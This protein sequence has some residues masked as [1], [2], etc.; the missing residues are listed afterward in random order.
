MLF[1]A[2]RAWD[3]RWMS[4][5]GFIHLRVVRQLVSGNGLVFNAGERVEAS[6]SPL[7]VLLLGTADLLTPVRLEWLAVLG[8]IVL[9]LVGVVLAALA[10]RRLVGATGRD[11]VVFPV[12]LAVVVAIPAMWTFTSSG[13][14]GGLVTA[15]LGVAI[16][17]MARWCTGDAGLSATTA[18]FLGLGPL[19]RPD[20]AIFAGVL[21]AVVLA[22]TWRTSTWTDRLRVV[23]LVAAVPVAYQVFRMG[24]YGVL[25]PNTAIAK[26]ASRSWWSNGWDYLRMTADPYWLWVPAVVLALGAYLPLV[27]TLR[28]DGRRR[29]LL[30]A[31]A[32]AVSGLVHLG[33]VLRVGGDFMPSRLLLPGI[34]A[35]CAPVAVLPVRRRFAAA[36]L[37]L[38][39]AVVCI[40]SLREYSDTHQLFRRQVEVEDFD[41]FGGRLIGRGWFD[42]VGLYYRSTELPADPSGGREAAVAEYGIGLPSYA[43]GPDVYII[44][45]LGLA[46]PVTAHFELERRGLIP[47]HEKPQPLPWMVARFADPPTALDQEDIPPIERNI[48]IVALDR[49]PRGSF[50]E[51][52]A[53]ARMA[54]SCRELEEL[55]ASYTGDLTPGRVLENLVESV[56]NTRL[57]Y[58][59]EPAD[60]QAELCDG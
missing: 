13:L 17:A 30:V 29:E 1:L 35:V 45:M 22:A 48:G 37:V 20:L 28:Q 49:R 36:A 6:T 51:R 58:P 33:Y 9:T 18:L 40:V 27:R 38:P 16:Y 54:L 12:G 23:A 25:V 32:F 2:Q 41:Q 14:E 59:A 53:A 26:E 4:D 46:D 10:S 55:R 24:Y 50:A 56:S 19:I 52:V 3:W 43:F 47:G 44:D 42:G 34:F 15:W 8:G 5:D 39:W 60:A 57:R 11:E 7:W 21:L 31:S